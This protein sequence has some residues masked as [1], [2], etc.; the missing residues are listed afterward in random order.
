[1]KIYKIILAAVSF[2]CF[3]MFNLTVPVV[4]AEEVR[5]NEPW[6]PSPL[7]NPPEL[8]AFFGIMDSKARGA[9]VL[10]GTASDPRVWPVEVE[11]EAI[12]NKEG[13]M[14]KFSI[15]TVVTKQ[16][17]NR[18]LL[19]QFRYH[20]VWARDL[21]DIFYDLSF[22]RRTPAENGKLLQDWRA[23]DNLIAEAGPNIKRE[24]VDEA[25]KAVR[26]FAT[27]RA[28]G[29]PVTEPV[30]QELDSFAECIDRVFRQVYEPRIGFGKFDLD[31]F[32]LVFDY[33][34][35]RQMRFMLKE[36]VLVQSPFR[37][38]TIFGFEILIAETVVKTGT[39][40]AYANRFAAHAFRAML[41]LYIKSRTE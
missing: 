18:Y 7:I 27:A 34:P 28:K 12:F 4:H 1:M 30:H 20:N 37:P 33:D 29:L 31:L 41:D 32:V 3:V 36:T 5:D 6:W 23:Y 14:I 10:P 16:V 2:F 25:L 26:E 24:I 35:S 39:C 13:T 8:E 40:S 19:R 9:Y 21:K 22:L 15:M 11:R 17:K 38:V